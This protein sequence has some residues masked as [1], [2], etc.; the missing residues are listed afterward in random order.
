VLTI[1]EVSIT[2][3]SAFRLPGS[4]G[5]DAPESVVNVLNDYMFFNSQAFYNL[6]SRAQYL[7]L[8]STD[9]ASANIR[10]SVKQV[11]QTAATGIASIYYDAKVYWSVPVGSSSN[12]M[13]IIYDTERKAW[14]PEAFTIGFERFFQYVN[15]SGT[16]KLLAWRTGDTKLT[17]IDASI[18][19]DYG[20]AFSTS[21]VTGLYPVAKNRFAFMRVA[22]AEVE[23]SQPAG[24]IYIE[25]IGIERSA[26]YS[27]QNSETI[28][29][30]LSSTGWSTFLW[31]GTSWSDTSTAVDTFSES[32]VKRYFRVQKELNAY[33]FRITTVNTDSDYLLRTLQLNGR[34]TNSGKPRE[35]II[36]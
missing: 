3:P 9:E 5:T 23:F 15:T 36:N 10:P 20:A 6:G 2:V 28:E 21:L 17:E 30:T 31:S 7:N 33:Q 27:S 24:T 4:R 13:T 11:S 18:N 35:W 34:P 32:S 8:L 14:L 1:G 25:L 12:N 26:G 22:E 29:S 16:R 19:G